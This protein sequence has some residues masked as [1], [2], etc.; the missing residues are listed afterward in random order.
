MYEV[1]STMYQDVSEAR[2]ENQE[3]RLYS[4]KYE[5]LMIHEFLSREFMSYY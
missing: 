5:I 4:L 1:L 2:Y 3:T